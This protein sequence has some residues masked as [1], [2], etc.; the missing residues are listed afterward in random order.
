M[1]A[2]VCACFSVGEK[3]LRRAILLEGLSTVDK[4]GERLRAG[5]SCGSCVSEIRALLAQAGSREGGIATE[6]PGKR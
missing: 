1:A 4:V 6:R 3:A 5:T 2:I